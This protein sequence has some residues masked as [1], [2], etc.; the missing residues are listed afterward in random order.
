MLLTQLLSLAV[1]LI[2]MFA[3]QTTAIL[4]WIAERMR[5][6]MWVWLAS[7][8]AL[9]AV[10]QQRCLAHSHVITSFNGLNRGLI[11]PHMWREGMQ[12]S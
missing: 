1:S 9:V 10:T 4:A 7:E 2:A 3:Q 12:Q 8:E 5:I 6:V 11:K